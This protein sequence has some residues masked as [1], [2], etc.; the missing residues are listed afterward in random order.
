MW[1]EF[2]FAVRDGAWLYGRRLKAGPANRRPLLCLAGLGGHGAQFNAFAAFLAAQ[3]VE[4]RDV[5]TLDLFGRGLSERGR[6]ARDISLLTDAQDALDFMTMM[7]LDNAA[8]LGSGHGGQVAMIMSL[9][10]PS[11][12]ATFVFNDAAPQMEPDGHVRIIGEITNLPM[13]STFADAAVLQR[14][15]HAR[16]FPRLGVADWLEVAH[17]LYLEADGRPVRPCDPSVGHAYSLASGRVNASLWKQFAALRHVPSLVLR[18]EYSDLVTARTV[19]RMLEIH[20]LLKSFVVAQE[21]HT[22]MLLDSQ[23][24]TAVSRYLLANDKL[25]ARSEPA[26]KSAA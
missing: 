11:C 10:R 1:D 15:M 23:V 2:R 4:A 22:P 7:G 5:Y 16:A 13:P 9:L 6:R 17:A 12:A 18:G 20:P 14:R 26:L 24:Q 3:G 8:I 19:A 25:D 21:G